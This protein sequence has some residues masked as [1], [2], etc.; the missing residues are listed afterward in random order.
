M[1]VTGTTTPS[2]NSFNA[3]LSDRATVDASNEATHS[4]SATAT[5]R[6]LSPNVT[7][8]NS[9]DASTVTAG[10]QAGFTVTLTN[11]GPGQANGVTLTDALPALGGGNLWSISGGANAGSFAITGAA[12]SQQLALSGVSTLAAGASLTVHITGTALTH[13]TNSAI[14]DASNELRHNQSASATVGVTPANV[15]VTNSADASTVTAGDQA[16]FTVTLTNT[17]PSQAYGLTLSD[18]LPALGGSNLW[19]I[20]GGANAGSFTITGAPGSQQLALSGVST[21]AVGASLTVHITGTTTPSATP[22]TTTLSNQATVDA[23]NQAAHPS[24]IG[25]LHVSNFNTYYDQYTGANG[26]GALLPAVPLPAGATALQFSATGSVS[27]LGTTLYG[28]D[29]FGSGGDTGFTFTNSPSGG[30]T[31]NGTPFGRTTGNDPSLYGI[32]FNPSFAGTPA[33]S[34]NYL[35][36]SPDQRTL[37]TYSPSVNQPFFIGDGLDHNNNL[38]VTATGNPQTFNVPAGASELLLGIGPDNNL[39]DNGGPGYDVTI[40]DNS[41]VHQSA[42]ATVVVNSPNVTVTKTADAVSVTTGSQAG[43]TVTLTNTGLGQANGLTLTDALPALGG[44]NVWNIS[45]GANAGS[46]AITGAAGSQQLTLSGVSTLAAGAPLTVHI[47]GTTTSSSSPVTLANAAIVDAGNELNHNQSASASIS[48]AVPLPKVSINSV[49]L[50]EGKSG[51]TP[52]NF[53]VSLA[54]GGAR[55]GPVSFDVFTT[56]GTAKAGSNYVAITAGD[57]THGGTVTFARGATTATVTVYVIAGS[58][59]VTPATATTTFTVSLSDPSRPGIPLATGTATIIAQ[60][61]KGGGSAA[62]VAP[63]RACRAVNR[64]L[65]QKRCTAGLAA[66]RERNA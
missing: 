48:V 23:S 55:Y 40:F 29:G 37:S 3:I 17:G 13:L 6:V 64:L 38:G 26:G 2:G 63:G 34:L 10:T 65:S 28:P 27:T 36:V 62:I 66:R 9:A 59:P 43:F 1:H 32:F 41:P 33:D 14:V 52:F 4:Q 11:T 42:T 22:F 21:L 51:L 47:T 18:A 45:G 56:D 53:R 46:F 60:A 16:G 57:A 30:G 25:P 31:Y 5:V 49:S 39:N 8:T 50:L 44:T 35:N 7:V 15:T 24:S 58:I 12:G 20:S 19:S 54:Q 61:P